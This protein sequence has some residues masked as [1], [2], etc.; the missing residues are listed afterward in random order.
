[1]LFASFTTYLDFGVIRFLFYVI[2]SFS[3]YRGK[4][5][6]LHALKCNV[7]KEEKTN[8]RHRGG[9]SFQ[10]SNHASHGALSP[11]AVAGVLSDARLREPQQTG[12]LFQM[13]F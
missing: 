10:T 1:M 9:V 2:F 5:N 13:N 4:T 7:H 12:F 3:L 6:N 8:K 11:T